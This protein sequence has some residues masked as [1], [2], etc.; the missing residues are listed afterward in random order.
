[1]DT[2]RK[3]ALVTGANRGLGFE[4]S[5]QLG[6]LGYHVIVG[7]RDEAKGR[8]ACEQLRAQKIEATP[9]ALDVSQ[10]ASVKQAENLVRREFGRLDALVNNAGIL[11]DTDLDDDASALRVP[12]EMV[13]ETFNTNTCGAYRM[14]Q[15][16]APLL[17]ETAAQ[18]APVRI[19]NVSSGMG[20]LSEMNG[21][22]PAYRFSKT[23]LNALTRVFAEELGPHGIAVNSICPGWVKT[24]MGGEGAE[25]SPEQG[26]DTIV[27]AATLPKDGPTGGFFRERE[28]IDW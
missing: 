9:L 23:A 22:Y 27:W 19:V 6:K 12:V 13:L 5:R 21:G 28:R 11:L 10:S 4:T 25:L 26:A 8:K 20:Q 15:A 18:G 3:I 14:C 7:S 1:M 16:F 17:I 24:D 2:P